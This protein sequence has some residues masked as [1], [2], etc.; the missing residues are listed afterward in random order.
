V[1][2][3]RRAIVLVL[4]CACSRGK[5][6][7]HA[8]HDELG[9]ELHVAN[10]PARRVVSIAASTTEL[11]YAIG[12]G[13]TLV[14]VDVYS[15]YPPAAQKLPRVGGETDPSVEKIVALRPDI[16]VTETTANRQE[17]AEQLERLGIPT[18]VTHV[19][20]LADLD[21]AI[22]D[23]GM[24]VGRETQAEALV[25]E[26]HAR[27][28]AIRERTKNLPRVPTLLV[29][30]SDPLFVVGKETFTSEL[31]ALAGGINVTDDAG[32]GFPKYSLER[33]LRHAPE[34]IIV[35]SHKTQAKDPLGYWQR[36]PDLPAV[37]DGRVVG[38]DGDLMFRPGPRL[39]DGAARL[40][41][42]IHAGKSR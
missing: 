37:R 24:L 27:F 9:R 22:R 2:T 25:T 15:D 34:V 4:L 32:A 30:W 21:R 5:P 17:T 33:V 20:S 36:W 38:L 28:D 7:G 31:I 42:V 23:L 39:A 14:G 3:A 41:E 18:F 8:V 1:A 40:F 13:D 29:V 16:V 11:L 6:A 35:G 10:F 26:M 12:A 19:Q